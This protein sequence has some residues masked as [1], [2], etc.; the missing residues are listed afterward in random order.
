MTT[1]ST[2]Q[3]DSMPTSSAVRA[4]CARLSGK[5]K[6]PAL[7]YIS[8]NFMPGPI[9]ENA[10]RD[11]G[12]GPRPGGPGG[13]TVRDLARRTAG[14]E[15][16][17]ARD[18]LRIGLSLR[19][20]ER[21]LR[22]GVR[23]SLRPAGTERPDEIEPGAE[24][25]GIDLQRAAEQPLGLLRV[26]T[27]QTRRV[28]QQGALAGQRVREVRRQ[29]EGAIDLATEPAEVD[30]R[31]DAEA[32]AAHL[33]PE[34]AE[35]GEVREGVPLVI[36]DGSF[37]TRERAIEHRRPL[38][39][40]RVVGPVAERE[41]LARRRRARWIGGPRETQRGEDE[42]GEA[43]H[44]PT[45]AGA[46]HRTN[47]SLVAAVEGVDRCARVDDLGGVTERRPGGR[48]REPLEGVVPTVLHPEVGR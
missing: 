45:L 3:I 31:S 30:Q 35:D 21:T 4:R 17:G 20:L 16:L 42:C 1:C 22:L 5:P 36:G 43:M 41:R 11:K 29:L 10:A 46:A 39:L 19:D 23:L 37:G 14:Q 8:P 26:T 2:A 13:G 27:Q 32:G 38:G 9:V 47:A 25:V 28:E 33:P 15:R 6:G 18:A 7:A 24:I 34:A 48:R 44:P 12:C 40:R